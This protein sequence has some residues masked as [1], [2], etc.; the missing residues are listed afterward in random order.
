MKKL[1][2]III[3]PALGMLLLASCKK[4]LDINTDPNNPSLEQG[5]AKL[6][7][8][9]GVTS[10]AGRIGG[11]LAILGG[12]WSQYYTQNTTSNQYKNI[13]AFQLSKSDFGG[14]WTELFAG[15]LN[16]LNYVISNA[17]SNANWNYY[18]MGTV[19]RA[20][21]YQVLVDLYDK[22]PYTEAFK[23]SANLAPKFD[24]GYDVYKGL[25]AE[26]DNALSKDFTAST[27][28]IAGQS[29]FIFPANDDSWTIDNW[30]K[31][32]NT[33]KLKMYL[34]M[35]FAKPA[36]ADAGI[37]KMYTDGVEFLDLDASM[38]IF[39]DQPDKSNPFYE[40]NFRKLNTDGNLRASVT[41]LSWLEANS[42][43]REPFYFKPKTNGNT[44][45]GINQGDFLNPDPVF[46]TA[47]K[48]NVKATDPV[49]FISLSESNF[50]QAE[51]LLRYFGDAGA[52]AKYDAGVSASFARYGL[53]AANFT[54]SGGKYEYPSGGTSEQKLEA[55]IVQKW[56]SMPG[57]H[58]LEAYFEH[59][60]TGY[61]KTSNVYSTSNAYVPGQFVYPLNGVTPNKA[62]A[63]RLIFP[64][65]ERSKNPNTPKEESIT[66]K[67]WWD[68]R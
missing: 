33:L 38:K 16:D 59:N 67:V 5:S 1:N 25:I 9:A 37:K 39:V 42:D 48:P 46:G 57:S 36:D 65:D 26:I 31:F 43:T 7:F 19:I 50:L 32:A 14:D 3:F 60:R 58:A 51:A 45:L 18:L 44:Y 15:S 41:F 28:I 52:K 64:D 23:G 22:V 68:V 40:Y 62:F 61:P 20:Y 27:N 11:S 6:V 34:R 66:T 55:I 30:I 53:S 2:K 10:S 63:K 8:P 47:S 13:D 4:A 17:K 54:K 35:S 49:D 12:I 21:T 24:N 56:A 29:D